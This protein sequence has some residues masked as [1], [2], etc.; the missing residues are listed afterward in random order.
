M[1]AHWCRR[2][3][4]TGQ[5]SEGQ[6][7]RTELLSKKPGGGRS[8]PTEK[9]QE[10]V[11]G[12]GWSSWLPR[13]G[14]GGLRRRQFLVAL[15]SE[16]AHTA[17]SFCS[18][19]QKRAGFTG[20]AACWA[21]R[22]QILRHIIARWFCRWFRQSIRCSVSVCPKKGHCCDQGACVTDCTSFPCKEEEVEG[23]VATSR[24]R[25]F[26]IRG[27]TAGHRSG[28]S[29]RDHRPR[30]SAHL[31]LSDVAWRPGHNVRV[32]PWAGG[33]TFW[34]SFLPEDRRMAN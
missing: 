9:R 10:W 27:H 26:L 28:G 33:K 14:A 20:K 32:L 30:V 12:P 34:T 18:R 15:A 8:T 16:K 6:T 17:L 5:S 3:R 24:S 19:K 25:H 2:W 4:V 13:W 1:D 31:S 23:Q 11:A 7:A 22:L 21:A 29:V